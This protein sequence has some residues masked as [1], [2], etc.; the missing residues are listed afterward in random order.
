MQHI[1]GHIKELIQKCL[2]GTS[3]P[4]E[5]K[6]L[7]E[8]YY[9]FPPGETGFLSDETETAIG[10]R[11]KNRLD[12]YVLHETGRR[13]SR[14]LS[15][16]AQAAIVLSLTGIAALLLYYVVGGRRDKEKTVAETIV[17]APVTDIVPGSNK[18]I[19]TL[20]DGTNVV[21]DTTSNGQVST[22]GNTR[23]IKL[24]N[25]QLKYMKD[26]QGQL[27]GK[28]IYN[29][30][31]TPRGGQY[32][33][34]LSDGSK[35]WL[36]ASSSLRFPTEFSEKAREVEVTG[37]A[38]CEI[39][40]NAS[41]PFRVKVKDML[42]SVLG[43][44][45]DVMAYDDES[46]IKTT[47]LEGSLQVSNAKVASVITPGQQAI[48]HKNGSFQLLHDADI[49][50]AVAWKN[51]KFVFNSADIHAIMRQVERW[52]DV[53]ISFERE[54]DLHFTGQLSRYVNVSELLRKLE[55][56]HEVHFRIE[57]GRITVLP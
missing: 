48:L 42:V 6:I 33:V 24:D 19:L 30:I 1:P 38:Y 49:E 8:W 32:Q 51:G 53:D 25:G 14:K 47:L 46:A 52:Y 37:E 4:E 5:K 36:N 56:T 18:A 15:G 9:N 31:S 45:F 29:T 20:G 57:K 43:T 55:L 54:A 27:S 2:D 26:K 40:H 34:V 22:Q 12:E 23:V 16:F 41:K 10:R 28:T 39:V 50:E 17:A 3:T 7:D 21:L 13:R 11:I 44:R 35:I